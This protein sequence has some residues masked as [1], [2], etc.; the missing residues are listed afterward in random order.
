MKILIINPFGIGDVLF[1]TPVIAALRKKFP[2]SFIA[3]VCN[4]S[5]API[6]ENNP[7][8]DQ[9]L[10]YSRGDFKKIRRESLGR[11]LNAFIQAVLNLR[12]IKFDLAID[13]SMVMQYSLVLWLVGV[14]KRFGFDYKNRGR[15]LTDKI[16]VQAFSDK[17][18]VDYYADLLKKIG[19]NEFNR[20]LKFYLSSDDDKWA[21]KY[22]KEHMIN[23]ADL[24]VG[25]AP[26][27]GLSWGADAEN[28][29]WPIDSYYFIAKHI[30]EKHKAKVI[31]FG[32]KKDLPKTGLFNQL[33]K[34]NALI[35]AVGQTS[36]GQLAALLSK[37]KL[38]I[39]NDSGPLHIAC[40]LD[41]KTVS[42]YGPVDEN[43]YGPVGQGQ[44]HDIVCAD[45]ACRPCYQN[46]KKPVCQTMNCL[47]ML[48]KE[49]VLAVV[50]KAIEQ[51][52][53]K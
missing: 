14:P 16:S 6:L 17:H 31:L 32:T 25:L 47:Q 27:G 24:V 53:A 36:L 30:I 9:L 22:L 35:N 13:L 21:G 23:S 39:C 8:I 28:K 3:Y 11:Y 49:K 2:D 48:A 20:N 50:E 33:S 44:S 1:S 42:V 41:I 40:A 45:I 29:Q 43:V 15:F 52:R 12:K 51:G 26:F 7:D 34:N 37:C 19:I 10:F 46:F 38:F 4:G 18:V 5:T